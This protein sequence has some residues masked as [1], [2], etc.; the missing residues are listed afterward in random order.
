VDAREEAEERGGGRMLY[1][2]LWYR[3]VWKIRWSSV[4]YGEAW[5]DGSMKRW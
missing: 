5:S 3:L 4:C 2:A 1:Y